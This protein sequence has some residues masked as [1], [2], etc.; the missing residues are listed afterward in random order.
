MNGTIW[1][2]AAYSSIAIFIAGIAACIVR[3]ARLPAHLRWEL[4]PVPHDRAGSSYGGSY[5][6]VQD[7][8]MKPRERSIIHEIIYMMK[9]IF[10]LHTVWKGHRR[11]WPFSMALHGGIYFIFFMAL[12]LAAA[13]AVD[14]AGFSSAAAFLEGIAVFLGTIGYLFGLAG[15]LSLLVLRAVRRDLRSYSGISAYLNLIILL[16]LFATG[17]SSLVADGDLASQIRDFIEAVFRADSHIS[18]SRAGAAHIGA[19][20]FFL[21]VLPFTSMRHF[22]AKFFTFHSV[23]WDDSPMDAAAEEKI[24]KLLGQ[25]VRWSAPHVGSEGSKNWIDIAQGK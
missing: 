10:L 24:K 21:A 25:P 19:V 3:I 5:F 15:S 1:L 20:L 4:A 7:W 22:A 14:A 13:A 12:C 2:I 11:L 23:L 8:W 9:E 6:E 18:L 17:V 16:A